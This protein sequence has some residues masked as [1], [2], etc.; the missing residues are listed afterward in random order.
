[1]IGSNVFRDQDIFNLS[2]Q[3]ARTSRAAAR[4]VGIRALHQAHLGPDRHTAVA[5]EPK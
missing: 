1:M 3:T 5:K 4:P 2:T